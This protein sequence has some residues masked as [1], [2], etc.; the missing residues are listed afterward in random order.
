MILL[1]NNATLELALPVWGSGEWEESQIHRLDGL[2]HLQE[3]ILR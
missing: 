3:D 2:H 1:I